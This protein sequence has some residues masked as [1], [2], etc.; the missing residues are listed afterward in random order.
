MLSAKAEQI[1]DKVFVQVSGILMDVGK[2]PSIVEQND[3]AEAATDNN[4]SDEI[5]FLESISLGLAGGYPREAAI[6]GILQEINERI[7]QLHAV[8]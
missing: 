2:T 8:R 4:R 7:A 5:V 3:S 1:G 6:K